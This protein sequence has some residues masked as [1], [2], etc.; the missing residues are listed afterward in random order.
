[1]PLALGAFFLVFDFDVMVVVPLVFSLDGCGAGSG[2]GEPF[3]DV[4]FSVSL[5]VRRVICIEDRFKVADSGGCT[6][7]KA[8]QS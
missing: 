3:S 8:N 4:D 5:T 2:G 7:R 1:M 6:W